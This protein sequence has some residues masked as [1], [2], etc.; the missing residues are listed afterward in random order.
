[1]ADAGARQADSAVERASAQPL[2][3]VSG[4]TKRYGALIAVDNVDM[5]VSS[6]EIRAVIG[7][8]GAGKTTLFHLI[9]GVVKPTVGSVRFAGAIVEGQLGFTQS[10]IEGSGDLAI[11]ADGAQVRGGWFMGRAEI[12]GL[13]RLPA[14]RI[15]NEMRLRATK[16]HVTTGPALF[17]S[18]VTIARELVLDGGFATHGG[19][20]L[21]HAVID[22]TLELSGSQIASAAI[23][24]GDTPRS[25]AHGPM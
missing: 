4:L 17:A 8:N 11:R 6:G 10:V 18:G 12:R 22:G 24:R 3:A 21:D 2:I 9:T 25:D 1:M 14:A 13:V 15:G 23:A 16:L 20:V 5:Q 7:P 19:V